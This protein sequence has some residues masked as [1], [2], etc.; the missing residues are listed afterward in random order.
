MS[1]VERKKKLDRQHELP[2]IR[3][4]SVLN[5][6]RSSAYREP[7]GESADDIDLMRKLDELHLRH[8]FKGS[9]RLRDDLWDDDGLRVNRKRV[10]R[11]MRLMGIRALHPGAKTTRPNPQH[12]IYPYLLRDLEIDRANQVW[13]TDLTYIPMRKGFLYLVAIMDW[14]SRKVLAWRL[15][16]SLDAAPCVEALEEALASYGAPEVFNSD[17]GCQFTSEDFTDTLKNHGIKISMDGKG[18]WIDNVF[19]ERLWRSLK[20]EEVYLKA[21]DSVAQARQGIGDWLMFYN[22]ER[23]H[24]SLGRMTPDQVYYDLPSGLPIAA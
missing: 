24:A 3:Q 18:R 12:K 7:A 5:I 4:C 19:I 23:R 15:S 13:C 9:R 16:N 14:H 11:L 8:P 17:Q 20:Y 2:I 22:Q 1:R 10:Q 21:Y 6:S